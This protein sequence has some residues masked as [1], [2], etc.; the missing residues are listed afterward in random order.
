MK[1]GCSLLQPFFDALAGVGSGCA[2]YFFVDEQAYD[3]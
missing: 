1:E 3:V 2:E